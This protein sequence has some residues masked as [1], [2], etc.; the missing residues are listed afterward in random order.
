M[1]GF[2]ADKDSLKPMTLP[3][4]YDKAH[5]SV[6]KKAREQYAKNQKGKCQHCKELLVNQPSREIM[7]KSINIRLFP[8]GFF[9][10]PIHLHHDHKTGLTISAVHARC[11]AVLWQYKGE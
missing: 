6:R 8:A 3:I 9:N 7:N 11:N 4:D 2:R 5:W 1:F 10:S